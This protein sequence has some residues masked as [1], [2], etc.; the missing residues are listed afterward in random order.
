M[1]NR[2]IDVT[3]KLMK[4]CNLCYDRTS[5][6]LQPWCAQVCPTQ[7]LWYGDFEQFSNQ[8]RGHAVRA[9]GFGVQ[10]IRTKVFHVLPQE[11]ARLEVDTLLEWTRTELGRPAAE[12][13]EAWVL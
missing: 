12:A 7:A 5:Q 9:T 8:R 13:E 4:K 2:R 6:D 1:E 11:V 3:A 10:D